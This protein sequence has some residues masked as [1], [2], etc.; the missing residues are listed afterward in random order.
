MVRL[1]PF[2]T[3]LFDFFLFFIFIFL[4]LLLLISIAFVSDFS[5]VYFCALTSISNMEKL[6]CHCH[7]GFVVRAMLSCFSV[8]KN[9]DA[10]RG[11]LSYQVRQS[12]K[13]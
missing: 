11:K 1:L 9:V 5:F 3:S 2:Y 12:T 10:E 6:L 8:W 4:S 13:S 7:D